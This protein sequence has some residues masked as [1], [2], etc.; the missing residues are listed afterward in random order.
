VGALYDHC[1]AILHRLFDVKID[2][3]TDKLCLPSIF[4]EKI[5]IVGIFTQPELFR[6]TIWRDEIDSGGRARD[7][8]EGK[9]N[10]EEKLSEDLS[11]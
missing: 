3:P 6:T 10:K 2:T 11:D 5:I 9:R 8:N 1:L 7:K 4:T